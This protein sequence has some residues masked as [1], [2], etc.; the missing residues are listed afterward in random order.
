MY[1]SRNP[2]ENAVEGFS[3][4]RVLAGHYIC[5]EGHPWPSDYIDLISGCLNIETSSRLSIEELQVALKRLPSPPLDLSFRAI[6][7][8]EEF[9][10]PTRLIPKSA[11]TTSSYSSTSPKTN[12]THKS[13]DSSR[14]P[15]P[16]SSPPASISAEFVADFSSHF[17]LTDST[18]EKKVNDS[19]NDTFKSQLEDDEDEFGDFEGAGSRASFGHSSLSKFTTAVSITNS[20]ESLP[21]E[22]SS[23]S[24]LNV[25]NK[26][27]TDSKDPAQIKKEGCVYILRGRGM[28]KQLI[29]KSVWMVLTRDGLLIRKSSSTESKIHNILSFQ[30]SLAFTPS[31]TTSIGMNGSIIQGFTPS[32]FLTHFGGELELEL[33]ENGQESF[34]ADSSFVTIRLEIAFDSKDIMSEWMDSIDL[35]RELNG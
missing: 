17:G 9:S 5:P 25:V 35:S 1:F 26:I 6:E 19:T 15:P 16:P 31:D 18:E 7:K 8:K 27:I 4:L 22:S 28:M 14:P 23:S 34:E 10:N 24:S 33:E 2:F 3:A 32:A 12:L 21:K 30:R 11:V 20:P 29:R 13:N